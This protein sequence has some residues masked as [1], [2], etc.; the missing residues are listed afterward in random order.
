VPL[1]READS[2][3]AALPPEAASAAERYRQILNSAVETGIVTMDRDGMVTGWSEGA[4]RILGWTE[5]EMLGQSLARVFPPD[6]GAAQLSAEIAEAE[7]R[8]RGGHEGWRVRKGGGRI[9]AIGETTPLFDRGGRSIGFVKILRDRTEQRTIELAL[10]DETRAL[11]I[12]N[13]V[14]TAL[15]RENDVARLV[16]MVIDAGVELTGAAFGAFF[17]KVADAAGERYM[18]HGLAGAERAAFDRFPMPRNT[19]LFAPTFSGAGIVR[20][21][22]VTGDPRYGGSGPHFGM[23]DGHLPVRSYLAVPVTARSGEVIGGLLFGHPEPGVFGPRAEARIGG[24]AAEAAIA[25]D[26]ARLYEAAQRELGERRR[27]ETALRE[28]NA[29][30]EDLVRQRTEELERSA[31]ALRQSQKMEALGQLTGGVAHDF[32]NLL[33]II[34]GNLQTL[35]RNLAGDPPADVSRL[36]QAVER[37][38][39]GASRA[40]ALTQRLLAFGRRQP[41]DPKP[42]DVNAL[43]SGLSELLRRTLGEAVQIESVLSAGTWTVDADPN[44][45][46]NTLINLAVNAR[47]AMPG[48]GRL[49]IET[50][51]AALDE[52]YAAR[53]A[54]LTPGDYVAISVSDTGVGMDEATRA[55]AF[56]PFFT[57]KGEGRGTG[58]GLSQA[59]GFVKQSRGHVKIY[60]EPGH[61]TTVTIY[62]PR[63]R[64]G[65]VPAPPAARPAAAEAGKGETILVVEDDEDVRA[66]SVETLRLLGYQVIEAPDGPTALRLLAARKVD[67]IF[68]D[69]V[70]PGGMTGADMVARAREMVPDMRVLFT[71]GYARNAIV[72]H[73]RLDRG[74]QLITKPFSFDA[75]AAKLRDVLGHSRG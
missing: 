72:H 65:A 75:L 71:T 63:L 40:A 58:L 15:A 17:R 41:L 2:L 52:A 53:D 68:T 74:V 47:D 69:V 32:N 51:N 39:T 42:I 21:D 4:T 59:Y 45:L 13:R 55:R 1:S 20:S 48:G 12:L 24:L 22:D 38:T 14:G 50:G 18:L 73:G 66:Y 67:L 23:P 61:G 29:S 5:A 28:L 11:E 34:V 60:S 27:V 36:R 16:Q 35:S 7:G 62:L 37:A 57:T 44:E 49:T 56:E 6:A 9:W 19:A 31:E 46:E 3:L 33:Q 10:L 70:L 43:V 30:L 26:N 54:E 8:G 25:I 64:G